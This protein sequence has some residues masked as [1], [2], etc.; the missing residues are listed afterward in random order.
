[1]SEEGALRFAI[2]THTLTG[3][4]R[5]RGQRVPQS[6]ALVSV[7]IDADQRQL[8]LVWQSALSLAARDVDFLSEARIRAS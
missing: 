8:L 6:Y 7:I 4:A 1:M 5:I 3:E 2:P